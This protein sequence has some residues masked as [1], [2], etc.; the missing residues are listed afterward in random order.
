[1]EYFTDVVANYHNYGTDNEVENAKKKSLETPLL[2]SFVKHLTNGGTNHYVRKS[3]LEEGDKRHIINS[4]LSRDIRHLRDN[5]EYM[6]ERKTFI[7]HTVKVQ[8]DDLIKYDYN[9]IQEI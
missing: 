1:M 5:I 8:D 3:I 7:Y 2:T 9:V 4:R 6:K